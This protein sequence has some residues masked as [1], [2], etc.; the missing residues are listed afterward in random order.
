MEY[1]QIIVRAEKAE[2]AKKVDNFHHIYRIE[3]YL[4]DTF[5]QFKYSLCRI[6]YFNKQQKS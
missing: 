4:L 1:E 5:F 6:N 3:Q 2:R